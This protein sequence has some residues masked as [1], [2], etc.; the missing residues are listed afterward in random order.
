MIYCDI[1][2]CKSIDGS[3]ATV[4][5]FYA[6]GTGYIKN[7]SKAKEYYGKACDLKNNDGCTNYAAINRK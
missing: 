7:Y 5:D 3:V 4:G 1:K 6:N 2:T